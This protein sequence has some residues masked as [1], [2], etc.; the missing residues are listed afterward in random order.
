MK[1]QCFRSRL[2]LSRDP[3]MLEIITV[4]CSW[5]DL[6]H[7]CMWLRKHQRHWCCGS[8]C[9]QGPYFETLSRSMKLSFTF[10]F[11]SLKYFSISE[12]KTNQFDFGEYDTY[13]A[14]LIM[15]MW[16]ENMLWYRHKVETW[17][18]DP[19]GVVLFNIID[20]NWFHYYANMLHSRILW[21]LILIFDWSINFLISNFYNLYIKFIRKLACCGCFFV[22][23]ILIVY[24]ISVPNSVDFD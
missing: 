7:G 16:H 23:L 24:Y 5:Y 15:F 21:T 3:L 11:W 14:I 4:K 6:D 2:Q 1:K 8:D 22:F 20:K 19:I 17:E 10:I 12:K 13:I 9:G 18:E